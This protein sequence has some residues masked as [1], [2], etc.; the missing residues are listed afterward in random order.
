MGPHARRLQRC[1]VQTPFAEWTAQSAVTG[2]MHRRPRRSVDS[3]GTAVFRSDDHAERMFIRVG[4]RAIVPI[5]HQC[6]GRRR[7]SKTCRRSLCD[8][9]MYDRAAQVQRF[10]VRR[11]MVFGAAPASSR[12]RWCR[13]ARER[14]NVSAD[15]KPLRRGAEVC[16][17]GRQC[18][19]A[20]ARSQP[21]R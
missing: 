19:V 2:L 13:D 17:A 1:L 11:V 4:S 12:R 6:H 20:D 14:R 21:E 16:A 9:T 18:M 8:V 5:F 10:S 3:T 7:V 15:L